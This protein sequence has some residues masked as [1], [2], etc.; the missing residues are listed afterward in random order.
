MLL[1]IIHRYGCRVLL[2]LARGQSMFLG[3]HL[4]NGWDW[5]L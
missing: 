2:T 5:C 3:A 4:E 1:M